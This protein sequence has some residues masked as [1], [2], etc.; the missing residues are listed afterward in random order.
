MARLTS[1]DAPNAGSSPPSGW[2]QG[3]VGIGIDTAGDVVG[4]YADSNN[5]YHGFL[6][7]AATG[8]ITDSTIRTRRRRLRAAG[9]PRSA[10]NDTGQI[11][12]YY[13]TG[14]YRRS[15]STTA[16]CTSIANGTFTEIDEPNAG[17]GKQLSAIRRKAQP[18]MAINASGVVTGYYVDSSGNR[19]GFIATP[20]ATDNY[21]SFD[22]P[23][24]TTNTGKAAA[25]AERFR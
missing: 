3:T 25:S 20:Y 11:V 17:T 2:F 15:R 16:F 1:F 5:A 23:G 9:L 22:A 13:T 4:I 19:H 21:T 6:R 24:A 14:S 10:I 8:T 18:Q 7:V 12:G